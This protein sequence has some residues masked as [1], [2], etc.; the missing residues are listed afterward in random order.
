V[1]AL[2]TVNLALKFALELGAIAAFAT[3][4]AS[5]GSGAGAVAL[6]I[7]AAAVAILLWGV[8]AAPRSTHRL[9]LAARVP[10]ELGVFALATA[11]TLDA[12]GPLPAIVFGALAILNVVLLTAL[13]QW[14]E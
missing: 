2:K 3:W 10:F 9:P 1:A 7:G 13:R 12:L 4:G 8:F 6:A 14:D 5:V 11:A